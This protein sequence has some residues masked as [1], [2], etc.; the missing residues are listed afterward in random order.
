MKPRP[1]DEK[2]TLVIGLREDFPR[3]QFHGRVRRF[4]LRALC[5]EPRDLC[6]LLLNGL[7][8]FSKFLRKLPVRRGWKS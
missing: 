5:K 4:R 6:F 3:M 8:E 7:T 2:P 1:S